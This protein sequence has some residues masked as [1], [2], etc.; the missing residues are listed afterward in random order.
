MDIIKIATGGIPIKSDA[1]ERDCTVHGFKRIDN[2]VGRE[3]HKGAS[4]GRDPPTQDGQRQEIDEQLDQFARHLPHARVQPLC[5]DD[6]PHPVKGF[7]APG[8]GE[9][10]GPRGSHPARQEDPVGGG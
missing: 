2:T 8:R 3:E 6:I 5:F 4:G 7:T 10:R 9:I 1:L